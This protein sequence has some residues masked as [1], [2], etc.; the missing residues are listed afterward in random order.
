MLASFISG[1]NKELYDSYMSGLSSCKQDSDKDKRLLN[2]KNK[3]NWSFENYEKE[4]SNTVAEYESIDLPA[5]K[6]SL[7]VTIA[8][9][10][11]N[12]D[13]D[14]LDNFLV[15]L[16]AASDSSNIV[17]LYILKCLSFKKLYNLNFKKEI[18]NA[19]LSVSFNVVNEYEYND[20]IKSFES[21]RYNMFIKVISFLT[22]MCKKTAGDSGIIE[23]LIEIKQE[24]IENKK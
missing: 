22:D 20:Q 19:L 4:M 21:H 3:F 9:L 2:E 8:Y 6:K 14:I 10:E 12:K 7:N 15:S 1:D 11:K 17:D 23:S 5:L 18:I 24:M 13:L 16:K